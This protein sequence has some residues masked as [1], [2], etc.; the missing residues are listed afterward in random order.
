MTK[1]DLRSMLTATDPALAARLSRSPAAAAF[2]ETLD[3]AFWTD[4]TAA[5]AY[6]RDPSLALTR[7]QRMLAA[8][9]AA[10]ETVEQRV[11]TTL[12]TE[13]PWETTLAELEAMHPTS[14]PDPASGHEARTS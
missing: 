2:W 6:Q 1:P 7:E 3:D 8:P 10:G 9:L 4:L 5:I 12:V 14:H 13:W 11:A